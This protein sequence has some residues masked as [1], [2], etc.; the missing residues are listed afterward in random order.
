MILEK[1]EDYARQANVN[2]TGSQ[3][4]PGR[5]E[6]EPGLYLVATPIGNLAD[7]TLRGLDTL[8]AC[9]L[10]ACEDTR[11]SLKLLRHFGI[12]CRLVSYNDH[13]GEARRP[14]ILASL[15]EGKRVALISDA[16]TPLISD[17]GYKLVREA[18]AQGSKVIPIPGAS[19]VLAALCLSA[20]PSDRFAF[21]GFLPA[22]AEARRKEIAA[23]AA[24]P[25][26]LVLFESARRLGD[27]LAELAR[28]MPG[29]QAAVLRELTKLYEE[30]R[31][32]TLEELAKHYAD[33]EPKG[34]IVL[35]IGPPEEKAAETDNLESRLALLLESHSVKEAAAILA[36]QTGLARKEIYALALKVKEGG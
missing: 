20:L 29:R 14:E 15:R 11:V 3:T 6:I 5:K 27:T 17:P 10:I 18:V 24:L 23:L 8:S 1:G 4:Q 7:I 34:E 25:M 36:E 19:S 30:A 21:I 26:S 22:R 2:P 16:G 28:R 13:N 9:D 35:V 12:T 31:R 32:G 33:A